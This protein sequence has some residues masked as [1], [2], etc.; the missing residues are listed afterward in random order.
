[1]I[2]WY[3]PANLN[4]N[5]YF[6]LIVFINCICNCI[7]YLYIVCLQCD[8]STEV[9]YHLLQCMVIIYLYDNKVQQSCDQ[10]RTCILQSFIE[11]QINCDLDIYFAY[12]QSLVVHRLQFLKKVRTCICICCVFAFINLLGICNCKF[13]CVFAFVEY[14]QSA[15]VNCDQVRTEPEG[16][17]PIRESSHDTA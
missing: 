1:M 13:C 5:L 11:L 16:E 8:C 10:V 6:C 2:V 7:W 15:V 17:K 14:Y 3:S 9:C 12:Y 4:V